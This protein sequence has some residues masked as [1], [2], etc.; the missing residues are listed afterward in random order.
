MVKKY[1]GR[2]L[3]ILGFIFIVSCQSTQQSTPQPA[4]PP[5]S[6]PESP[7]PKEPE[8][9]PAPAPEP[10]PQPR[11]DFPRP[12]ETG[13]VIL[14]GAQTHQVVW[15]DTLSKIA[16]R[17]YGGDNGYYYPLI[18]L[19]NPG[20]AVNPDLIL[21]GTGLK[22]PDLRRNL[23]NGPARENLKAYLEELIIFYNRKPDRVMSANL[24]S[25]ANKL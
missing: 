7:P 1:F 18:I 5:P 15:G 17:Y 13:N 10:A 14:E 25:L 19:G 12:K 9:Q 24:R 23:D 3:L 16:I 6:Q 2:F 8:P 11:G 21:P 4:A 22:I 20:V